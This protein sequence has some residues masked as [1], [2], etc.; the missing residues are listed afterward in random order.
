MLSK[1]FT[2]GERDLEMLLKS[3]LFSLFAKIVKGF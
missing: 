2:A 3:I 1:E